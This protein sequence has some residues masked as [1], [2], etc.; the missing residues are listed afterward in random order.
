MTDRTPDRH[1]FP[2]MTPDERKRL[3]KA[4]ADAIVAELRALR[5]THA[6]RR[7]QAA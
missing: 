4:M 5:A 6:Q 2:R 7:N 1:P 3:S